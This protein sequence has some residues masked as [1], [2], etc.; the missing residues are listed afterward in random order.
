[1][2]NKKYKTSIPMD[3]IPLMNRLTA[4]GYDT[5][6][7]WEGVRDSVMSRITN[8][9]ILATAATPNQAAKVFASEQVIRSGGGARPLTVLRPYR[10][11]EIMSYDTGISDFLAERDFTINAMAYSEK[12]GLIDPF[13]GMEDIAA[14]RIRCVGEPGEYFKENPAA[15]MRA[16]RLS[17]E[18]DF[19]IEEDTAKAMHEL[20]PMLSGVDP[21]I[22]RNEFCLAICGNTDRFCDHVDLIESF[23]PEWKEMNDVAQNNPWHIYDLRGHTLAAVRAE[24]EREP[25][26]ASRLA[27]FFHDFGKPDTKTTDE[28]GVDH[29]LKHGSVGADKVDIILERLHFSDEQRETI[30]Q[31]VRAHDDMIEPTEKCANRLLKKFGPEQTYRLLNIKEDDTLA[32]DPVMT[33]GQPQMIR[34][35]RWIVEQVLSQEQ[36]LT[37]KD[38]TIG[39]KDLLNLFYIPDKRMIGQILNDLLDS[40]VSGR[41]PNEPDALL[42]AAG[43]ILTDLTHAKEDIIR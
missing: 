41:I 11:Y 42:D 13:G 20:A 10:G 16:W 28:Q 7:T 1:M 43:D 3:L 17:C 12:D 22:L 39:G 30:T 21:E 2:D 6:L 19:D 23:I 40:V 34:D 37:V 36:S 9:Y 15:I 29:F 32:Q 35:L 27:A 38:L 24:G 8:D 26:T 33:A 14:R 31:L 4:A 5:Y 25:D 18:L